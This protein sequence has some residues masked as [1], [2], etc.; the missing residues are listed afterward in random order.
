MA[1][2]SRLT[3]DILSVIWGKTKKLRC[4]E[5]V[6]GLLYEA[7]DFH[8]KS[9]MIWNTVANARRMMKDST[10]LQQAKDLHKLKESQE[11]A[12]Q[13][14]LEER[15]NN[16]AKVIPTRRLTQKTKEEEVARRNENLKQAEK[17]QPTRYCISRT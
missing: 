17:R 13:Q 9:A 6:M 4:M 10:I 7:T 5:V 2:I 15:N 12:N 1:N 16:K 14:A 8:P 11:K 3:A